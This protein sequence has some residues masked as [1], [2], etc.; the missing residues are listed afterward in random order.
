MSKICYHN[1]SLCAVMRSKLKGTHK[2]VCKSLPSKAMSIAISSIGKVY[3]R[4][5]CAKVCKRK[6][7]HDA[8]L[9]NGYSPRD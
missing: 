4:N 1:L 9:D 5:L 2:N 8:N 6:L 7:H 3:G